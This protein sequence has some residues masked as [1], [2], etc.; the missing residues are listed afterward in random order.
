MP[1]KASKI[2]AKK[3]TSHQNKLGTYSI[4]S[5]DFFVQYAALSS[6]RVKYPSGISI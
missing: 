2:K 5:L 6:Y 3:L 4:P 1:I